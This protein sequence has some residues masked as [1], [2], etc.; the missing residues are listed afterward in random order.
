MGKD[1]IEALSYS[2]FFWSLGTTSFR[3]KEFNS[4]IEKQLACLDDFWKIPENSNQGWERKYMAKGQSDIYEI[5]NKY[6]DYMRDR[7]LTSGDDGIK[8]KAAREKTSGLVDLGLI[9]EN[10]RLTEVG[11]RILEISQ[12]ND[13]SSD[14]P[15]LISKDSYIYLKQLLKTCIKTDGVYV[16]PFVVVLYLLSKLEYLTYEEFTFLVPLCTSAEVTEQMIKDILAIRQ[17]FKSKE[18]IIV[19]IIMSK[20]NYQLAHQVLMN[21]TV[22]ESIIMQIGL[23]RKSRQYDR[24][25]YPLY[26]LLKEV[27]L[28]KDYSKVHLLF[29]HTRIIKNVGNLWRRYLFDTVSVKAIRNAPQEHLLPSRFNDVANEKDFKTAFFQMMHL[30]KNVSTL[31][32]YFDLNRRY[33]SIANVMIFEDGQVKLDLVPKQFFGAAIKELYQSAYL[34]SSNLEQN[35]DIEHICAALK[36]NEEEVVGRLNKELGVELET[37]NEAYSEVEKRRYDRF[38]MMIDTRFTDNDL[39]QLLDDFN[40]RN[41]DNISRKVTDNADTPTIFEYILGI[42]WYKISNYQGKILDFMKLSLDANLL[43]ITH[44]A[45]GEADIVYEYSATKD[46]P[47]HTLL[48]EATLADST[49]QRRMEMEPVSRHLGNHILKTNNH[50]SYCVFA[51]NNLHVNVISDFRMRKTYPYYDPHDDSRYIDGMKIIPL[52]ISDLRIIIMMHKDYSELY[53]KYESAYKTDFKVRPKDWYEYYV[54][55]VNSLSESLELKQYADKIMTF[56]RGIS[57]L[58]LQQR[59]IEEFGEKYSLMKNTDWNKAI[60]AYIKDMTSRTDIQ[61]D[62]NVTWMIAADANDYVPAIAT[63]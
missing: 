43:P 42:I 17:G 35:C 3:T 34:P 4:S 51:T 2:S 33:L 11:K 40:N 26:L 59:I 50:N 27:Y 56:N 44:A 37:I 48:L 25:Y 45:G 38:R 32:D 58:Q 7:G 63:D 39:L 57:L 1:V 14:N 6:Y 31:Q 21:K 49:N 61:D 46:Y 23:N 47:A 24:P 9:N 28:N 29:K 62:E 55:S 52:Q 60:R 5:K 12:N 41:D 10:H 20:K 13:Y 8:Y 15:L 54:R 30:I 18:D 16:R 53:H 22:D 36:F 19:Q